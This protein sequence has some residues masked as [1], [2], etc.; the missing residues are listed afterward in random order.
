LPAGSS[1][2]FLTDRNRTNAFYS[3]SR[4]IDELNKA[5]ETLK[6]IEL[7]LISEL[8][9][10][11]HRSDRQVAKAI[12]ISQPTVS[13]TREKL[14]R[15]GIIK[16]YTMIPDFKKLG[17]NIM[18]MIFFKLTH[19]PTPEEFRK[20][21]EASREIEKRNPRAYLFVMNGL[22]FDQNVGLT[23]FFNDYAEYA[24]YVQNLKAAVHAELQ[25]YVTENVTGFLIDLSDNTHYQPITLSRVAARLQKKANENKP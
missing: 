1:V 3:A 19:A 17:F 5:L 21:Q 13:R 6:D 7:R 25:P 9:K 8:M 14:E 20:L 4:I 16:E 22:G 23:A 18:A 10:N 2:E 15:E 24:G 12:G 11:S